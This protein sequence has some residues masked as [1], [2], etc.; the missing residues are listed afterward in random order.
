MRTRLVVW[1][2]VAA[3]LVGALAVAGAAGAVGGRPFNVA[4]T[5]AQEVP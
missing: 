2:A 3:G 1:L 4:L 5:G